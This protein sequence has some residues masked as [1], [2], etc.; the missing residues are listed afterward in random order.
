MVARRA[1]RLGDLGGRGS[2]IWV[3]VVGTTHGLGLRLLVGVLYTP[4]CK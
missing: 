3:G 1:L 2:L 4:S